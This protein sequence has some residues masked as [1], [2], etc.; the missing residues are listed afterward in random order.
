MGRTRF[1]WLRIGP[2][3]G[4]CEHDVEPSIDFCLTS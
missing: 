2:V 3:L 4:F 1:G